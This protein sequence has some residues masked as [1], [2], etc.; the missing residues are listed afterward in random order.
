MPKPKGNAAK[1][2]SPAN[3]SSRSKLPAKN[4]A[5]AKTSRNVMP[6]AKRPAT[7]KSAKKSTVKA[8]ARSVSSTVSKAMS[9]A[10]SKVASQ[11]RKVAQ[12]AEKTDFRGGAKRV[13]GGIV[14]ATRNLTSKLHLSKSSA[15]EKAAAPKSQSAKKPQPAK[16]AAGMK[17]DPPTSRP[18]PGAKPASPPRITKRT[19]DVA[20][21][22]LANNYTPG[23][24]SLKSSFRE[25]GVARTQDQ[26]MAGGF[27]SERWNDED[28][29]TNK[30]GD[31]RIGTHGRTYEPDEKPIPRRK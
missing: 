31:P 2:K 27:S 29:F 15:K 11:A 24:T 25:G 14:S 13:V 26:E 21:D 5:K 20:L 8:T 18:Q 17:T 28:H 9:E 30:S 10:M 19:P 16:Q 7:S 4:P 23:H 22:E 12:S 6:A 3:A 1:K